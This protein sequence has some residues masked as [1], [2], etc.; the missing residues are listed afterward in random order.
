MGG[1]RW[2]R[3]KDLH[4][5]AMAVQ[6][7]WAT[8]WQV[9]LELCPEWQKGTTWTLDNYAVPVDVWSKVKP[10]YYFTAYK[11]FY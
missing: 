4:V 1:K 8:S 9:E 10:I 7:L 11:K 6:T 5:H 2:I 3:R